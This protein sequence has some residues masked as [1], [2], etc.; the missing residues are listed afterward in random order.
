MKLIALFLVEVLAARVAVAIAEAALR[1]W[2]PSWLTATTTTPADPFSGGNAATLVLLLLLGWV[3][4]YCRHR[5]EKQKNAREFVTAVLHGNAPLVQQA[6]ETAGRLGG[7]AKACLLNHKGPNGWTCLHGV[8]FLGHAEVMKV[9]LEAHADPNTKDSNG[10]TPL[11]YACF[12]R[13]AAIV[14]I[15]LESGAAVDAKDN[16]SNTALHVAAVFG[17][18]VSVELL[19]DFEADLEAKSRRGQTPFDVA[20]SARRIEIAG[21]LLQR[22]GEKVTERQGLHSLHYILQAATYSS[23]GALSP[24]MQLPLGKLAM[25]NFQALVQFVPAD[26]IRTRDDNNEGGLPLH[27]AGGIGAPVELVR[28][29]VLLHPPALRTRD[30]TGSLP[31]HTSF[32]AVKPSLNA[33]LFLAELDPA[34]MHSYNKDGALPFHLLLC[35]RANST[36]PPLDVFKSLVHAF[37][38]SVFATTRDGALP[39]MLACQEASSESS[40]T[41]PLDLTQVLA[42]AHPGAIPYLEAYHS[43]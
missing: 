15:L 3:G 26:S 36:P 31:M 37:P 27:I 1:I 21:H 14:R 7:S 10:K 38:G 23:M 16:H 40:E 2:F 29:L 42:T 11:Q 12:F 13:R 43:A 5:Q 19:L 24:R 30:F 39:Y 34:A 18:F 35:G 28:I 6:L 17:D 20:V 4:Y 25:D 32:K 33:I 22:Y 41:L 9:L 8:C